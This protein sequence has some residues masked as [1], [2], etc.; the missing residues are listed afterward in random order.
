MIA[1]RA[2]PASAAEGEQ[3]TVRAAGVA[4]QSNAA[5]EC[6][7]VAARGSRVA[8]LVGW[9]SEQAAARAMAPSAASAEIRAGVSTPAG[10][11]GIGSPGWMDGRGRRLRGARARPSEAGIRPRLR[12]SFAVVP[13]TGWEQGQSGNRPPA[14]DFGKTCRGRECLDGKLAECRISR[15][16]CSR[17]QLQPHGSDPDPDVQ[18]WREY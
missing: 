7:G 18:H 10:T 16:A 3:V 4:T 11:R 6:P 2:P 17:A 14:R 1:P 15:N 12:M 13:R 8:T 9:L 5:S